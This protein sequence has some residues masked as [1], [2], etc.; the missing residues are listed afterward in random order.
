MKRMALAKKKQS[1]RITGVAS[2]PA[3]ASLK[4]L[5]KQRDAT[6]PGSKEEEKAVDRIMEAMFPDS[7]A[8]R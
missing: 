3:P 8:S 1:Q 2:A 5:F 7:H 6:K 4:E